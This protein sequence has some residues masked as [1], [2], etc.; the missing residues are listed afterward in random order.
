MQVDGMLTTIIN[1][2]ALMSFRNS[3]AEEQPLEGTR[4]SDLV[5]LEAFS[6]PLGSE[7][8][9]EEEALKKVCSV[10]VALHEGYLTKCQ[11]I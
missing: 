2:C 1:S 7:G 5:A 11:D 8:G 6:R 9:V 4:A 10:M 3:P